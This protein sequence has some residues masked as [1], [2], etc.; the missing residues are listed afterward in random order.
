MENG[1]R[2]R[3]A[4]P[5]TSIGRL[6]LTAGA[7]ASVAG[8]LLIW[9][10]R[11]SVHRPIYVSE[12]GARGMPTAPLFVTA[13]LLVAAG[14]ALIAIAG[15]HPRLRLPLIGTAS[16]G[17]TI[18]ISSVFFVVASQVS[19]TAG[20]PVPLVGAGSTFQDLVHTTAA[21]LG[22][23]AGCAAMLQVGLVGWRMRIARFSIAACCAVAVITII[24][25]MLSIFR[26]ATDVGGVLEF[27]G[28]TV[29]IGWLACYGLWLAWRPRVPEVAP[30]IAPE[31]VSARIQ[32]PA[33]ERVAGYER[34][35]AIS[36]SS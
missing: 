16:I 19:C 10:A 17:A 6:A 13:L 28:T 15:I 4:T 22:F 36:A 3:S 5:V 14:A 12:L 7:L 33:A 35:D 1:V 2:T 30:G 9:L 32:E 23:V 34:P 29:A 21:V 24:G 31:V 27:V 20:C 18:A 26:T 25:G 11:A 8:V